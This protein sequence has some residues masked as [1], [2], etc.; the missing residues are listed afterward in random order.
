MGVPTTAALVE[1]G[2]R[3][4]ACDVEPAGVA[5]AV[6][7][8]ATAAT[9][10]AVTRAGAIVHACVR[11]TEQVERIVFGPDGVDVDATGIFGFHDEGAV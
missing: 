2:H 10:A 4:T 5:A 9:P 7:R 1:R 8:G 11:H 3:V 6:A